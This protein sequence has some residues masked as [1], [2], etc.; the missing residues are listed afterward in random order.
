MIIICSVIKNSSNLGLDNRFFKVKWVIDFIVIGLMEGFILV[1]LCVFFFNVL[2]FII[3]LL[4]IFI[5]CV[6]IFLIWL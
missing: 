1:L 2:F 3:L 4:C 5:W 6:V